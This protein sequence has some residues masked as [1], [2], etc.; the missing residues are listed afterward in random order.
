MSSHFS[1]DWYNTESFFSFSVRVCFCVERQ[2]TKKMSE[3]QETQETH[4][5]ILANFQVSFGIQQLD[6]E[7]IDDISPKR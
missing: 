7:F 4:E 6:D 3:N 2:H 5:E 1:F